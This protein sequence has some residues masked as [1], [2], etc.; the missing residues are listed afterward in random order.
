MKVFLT[1]AMIVVALTGCASAQLD[2]SFERPTNEDVAIH[3]ADEMIGQKLTVIVPH[4]NNLLETLEVNTSNVGLTRTRVRDSKYPIQTFMVDHKRYSNELVLANDTFSFVEE[5]CNYEPG[6]GPFLLEGEYIDEDTR[7][8]Y[9]KD[10]TYPPNHYRS[11]IS[12][13]YQ[14]LAT[15]VGESY[16]FQIQKAESHHDTGSNV[17][18]DYYVSDKDKFVKLDT[19][20]NRFLRYT[21]TPV[22]IE[23]AYPREALYEALKRHSGS[24]TKSEHDYVIKVD[25]FYGRY[26]MFPHQ[27]I[28]PTED[29]IVAIKVKVRSYRDGSMA[30]L[31]A[32]FYP[33]IDSSEVHG[34]EIVIDYTKLQTVL[35]KFVKD[36]KND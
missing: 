5:V 2:Q 35:D 12:G 36:V 7:C 15:K 25:E 31:Y 3:K 23:S 11:F 33:Y 13:K 26:T 27:I 29:G 32:D 21:P 10:K 18:G 1:L 6:I 30:T 17:W 28:L 34:Q 20:L 16:Q 24:M 4:N 22:E 8:L 19:I 9:N 14:K